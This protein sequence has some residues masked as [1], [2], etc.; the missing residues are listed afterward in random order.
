MP[1][2]RALDAQGTVVKES[3][4]VR[5]REFD[6]KEGRLRISKRFAVSPFIESD[7]PDNPFIGP[8]TE[9][10][11]LG[12][13]LRGH[14]KYRSSNFAAGLVYLFMPVVLGGSDQVRFERI[15]E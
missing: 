12:I 4:F 10:V 9:T 13:D 1:C 8:M 5:G 11:E 2:R 7:A 15:E 14:G 3:A 6:L